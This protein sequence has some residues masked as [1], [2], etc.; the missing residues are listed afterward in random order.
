MSVAAFFPFLARPP[1]IFRRRCSMLST[2]ELSFIVS[3]LR[4]DPGY[5]INGATLVAMAS[6]LD[7][8]IQQNRPSGRGAGDGTVAVFCGRNRVVYTVL[9]CA[10]T[11]IRKLEV[12]IS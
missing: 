12:E 7:S 3:F 5:I 4:D 8:M 2:H 6:R 10:K 1:M 9:S 11:A